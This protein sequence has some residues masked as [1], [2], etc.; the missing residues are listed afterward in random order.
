[1]SVASKITIKDFFTYCIEGDL[2][3]AFYR[4]PEEKAVKIVAQKN[5]TLFKTYPTTIKQA[6]RKGFL[7]APFQED[8]TFSKIIIEPD[9]FCTENELPRLAFAKKAIKVSLQSK[10]VQAKLKEAT[11]AE[12]KRYLSQ[13]QKR[14]QNNNFKKIVAARIIKKKKPKTFDA[15]KFFQLLCKEHPHAFVSLVHTKEYGLWIGASPEILLTVNG[16]F[17]TASLAGTKEKA[18]ANWKKKEIQEQKI[19]SDYIKTTFSSITK[20]KPLVEGPNTITAGNLLHLKTTFTF[21]SIP[22]SEWPKVIEQLHPTPAVAGSPKEE[23]IEFILK[24]EKANRSFY[25]GYL[26]PVNLDKQINLFVNLRCMNIQKNKLII[27]TGCGITADSEFSKEWKETQIK[28]ETLL[29][30]LKKKK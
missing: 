2:C 19:V 23:A 4:L 20:E 18:K 10:K 6:K 5:S 14:I 1:M 15:V 27:Y 7:F 22:R 29:S 21:N 13:I 26:G 30:L 17:K 9:I 8:K 3:F 24:N 12:F 11:K 16:K 25:S 28:S